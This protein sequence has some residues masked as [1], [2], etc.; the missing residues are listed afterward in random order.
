MFFAALSNTACL[1]RSLSLSD[2]L[3]SCFSSI[4]NLVCFMFAISKRTQEHSLHRAHS[5]DRSV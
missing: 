4:F 2:R 3:F 1:I 5:L